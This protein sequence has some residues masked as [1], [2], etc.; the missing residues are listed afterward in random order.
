MPDKNELI[1]IL[2]HKLPPAQHEQA[3]Q[4]AQ[5]IEEALRSGQD[6]QQIQVD[7]QMRPLLD[8]LQSASFTVGDISVQ[9]IS[10]EGMTI[11]HG[12]AAYHIT[13]IYTE[14]K[15]ITLTPQA[16]PDF[17]PTKFIDRKDEIKIFQQLLQ[18]NGEARILTIRAG[19]GSGKSHLLRYFRHLCTSQQIPVSLV[20][21]RELP[22]LSPPLFID[23]MVRDFTTEQ[24]QLELRT[25]EFA[26]RQF[27]KQSAHD[28]SR[29]L[30]ISGLPESLSPYQ[31][32]SALKLNQTFQEMRIDG[33]FEDVRMHCQHRPA[34]LL[35]DSFEQCPKRLQEWIRRALVRDHFLQIDHQTLDKLLLVV[36]GV[37]TP[38]LESHQRLRIIKTRSTLSKWKQGDFQRWL[39]V[40][41][42]P[43]SRHHARFYYDRFAKSNLSLLETLVAIQ[44]IEQQLPHNGGG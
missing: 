23:E 1:D 41:G 38:L 12:S 10:G 15:K 2:R 44:F 16:P 14:P 20:D 22:N 35:L 28:W 3:P 36:A 25:Y 24:A 9:N 6:E 39:H 21:F 42:Y 26:K 30:G 11:G 18:F 43:A 32:D 33:F 40:N 13:I 31:D 19:S 37:D 34:V 29:D 4:I 27:E 7:S 8:T 17:D 5:L